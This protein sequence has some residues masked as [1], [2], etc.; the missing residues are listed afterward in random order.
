MKTFFKYAKH[1]AISFL[2]LI[3][4][5]IIFLFSREEEGT[6]KQLAGLI[7]CVTL[8][9]C[10]VP[11]TNDSF[12]GL[13]LLGIYIKIPEENINIKYMIGDGVVIVVVVKD[14]DN[15]ATLTDIDFDGNIDTVGL[16]KEGEIVQPS[17]TEIDIWK[18]F[19]SKS[20]KVAWDRAVPADIKEMLK[21]MPAEN[22]RSEKPFQPTT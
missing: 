1:L 5:F 9:T 18:T 7:A 6:E 10:E 8:N 15:Q 14:K 13:D 3:I 20:L 21:K 4:T 17:N 19:Y 2:V 12:L 11:T 16:L 22:T